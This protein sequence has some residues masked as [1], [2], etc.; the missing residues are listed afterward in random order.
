[1]HRSKTYILLVLALFLNF[2]ILRAAEP[3]WSVDM[4]FAGACC[5]D[6]VCPCIFD[7]DPTHAQCQVN[8]LFVIKRGHYDK[9]VLDGLSVVTT[10]EMGEWRRFY[11]D[12]KAS[13]EQVDAV[14]KLFE[15]IPESVGKV[16]EVRW[17]EKVPVIMKWEKDRIRFSTPH[18]EVDM[19]P[20]KGKGG[21]PITIENVPY[22]DD[23]EQ[24][25]TRIHKYAGHDLKFEFS[26]T[27]ASTVRIR[28][29]KDESAKA[30]ENP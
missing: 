9:V 2:G 23:Y 27:H 11:I 18:S 19:E 14:V 8:N 1:M 21:K 10:E 12:D 28:R 6:P 25:K 7:S 26:G 17:V 3:N 13:A 30:A 15:L 22:L 20:M 24:F 16:K 4:K 5:C 29:A